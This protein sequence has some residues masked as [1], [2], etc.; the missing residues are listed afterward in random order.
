MISKR[1]LIALVAEAVLLAVLLTV[2]LDQ[3]AHAESEMVDGVN[4][5]GYRGAVAR[6]RT[7]AETRLVMAGGTGAFDP[8]R[9]LKDTMSEQ[10]R[11]ITE[12]WV[13]HERGPVTAI[14]L[15]VVDLPRG[16]YARRLEEFR[17]L[18]PDVICLVVELSP[19]KMPSPEPGLLRRWTG[20][21]PALTPLAAVDRQMARFAGSEP[22]ASDDVRLVRDAVAVARSIAPT[23]VAI[24]EPLSEA[25]QR[26]REALLDALSQTA[27]DPRVKLIDL[28]DGPTIEHAGVVRS[29]IAV[30]IE[31]ATRSFLL[32]KFSPQ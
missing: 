30:Q 6:Q 12:Q 11:S 22:I 23:V 14:N 1:L 19:A 32:P 21:V 5:W 26:D 10:V 7:A 25:E 18:R 31:S 29:A 8:G 13:T 4:R 24:P 20:Y 3:Y 28:K 16:A 17:E 27:N 15:G 9:A 2:A